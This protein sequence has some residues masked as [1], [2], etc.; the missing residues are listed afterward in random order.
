M[1]SNGALCV[2]V[3]SL[4]AS[5]AMPDEQDG[6]PPPGLAGLLTPAAVKDGPPGCQRPDTTVTYDALPDLLREKLA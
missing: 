4:F 2:L 6:R 3:A 5:T 1:C